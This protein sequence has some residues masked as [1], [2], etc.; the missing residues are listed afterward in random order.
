[1]KLLNIYEE[2]KDDI[3]TYTFRTHEKLT[4]SLEIVDLAIAIEE[5]ITKAINQ[6]NSVSGNWGTEE[7]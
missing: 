7:R 2:I 3:Y 1:M 6:K 4:N 5:G